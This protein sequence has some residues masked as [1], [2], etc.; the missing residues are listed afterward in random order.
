MEQQHIGDDVLVDILEHLAPLG[1]ALV[2]G[3]GGSIGDHAVELGIGDPGLQTVG[4]IFEEHREHRITVGVVVHRL[5]DLSAATFGERF[6]I[7]GQPFGHFVH[8]QL[9]VEADI[10]EHRQ[11]CFHG[12]QNVGEVLQPTDQGDLGFDRYTVGLGFGQ[13][14]TGL[15]R[16]IGIGL[17]ILVIADRRGRSHTGGQQCAVGQNSADERFTIDCVVQRFTHPLVIERR[18]VIVDTQINSFRVGV[19]IVHIGIGSILQSDI[20]RDIGLTGSDHRRPHR[21][22]GAEYIGGRFYRRLFAPVIRVGR[23]LDVL[24]AIVLV[25]GVGAGT[26]RLIDERVHRGLGRHDGDGRYQQ[27]QNR[28]GRVGGDVDGDIVDDAGAQFHATEEFGADLTGN[29]I[30]LDTGDGVSHVL[31]R[32]GGAVGEADIR[33]QMETPGA[34]PHVLPAVS[35]SRLQTLARNQF[36]QG[37]GDILQQHAPDVGLR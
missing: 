16:I 9:H 10:L 5:N 33:M 6:G 32:E 29:G 15:V 27:G 25:E 35:Q 3:G 1:F 21:T 8:L 30:A 18:R 34:I 26:D 36:G 37:L 4:G 31:G 24:A 19:G 17:Q 11:Q 14:F 2:T 22:F 23:H 7:V 13:Q 20:R 28:L 12:L